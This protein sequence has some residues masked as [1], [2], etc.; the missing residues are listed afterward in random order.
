MTEEKR[1]VGRPEKDVEH[2]EIMKLIEEYVDKLENI[3]KRGQSFKYISSELDTENNR[4]IADEYFKK[5]RVFITFKKLITYGKAK[6]KP[7]TL[8]CTVSKLLG[9]MDVIHNENNKTYRYILYPGL[10]I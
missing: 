9:F 3:E 7:R 8:L 2:D 5:F 6:N 1:P 10:V 4:V